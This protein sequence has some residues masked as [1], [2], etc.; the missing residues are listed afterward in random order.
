VTRRY[1]VPVVAA[2][3]LAVAACGDDDGPAMTHAELADA[4]GCTGL[5]EPEGFALSTGEV[6][7]CTLAGDTVHLRVFE[8]N[9]DRDRDLDMIRGVCD[10]LTTGDD[11]TWFAG[12]RWAINAAMPA[13][14][15]EAIE[16]GT[17][18]EP[19]TV[20]C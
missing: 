5:R 19:V 17:G 6:A 2:L 14:A 1:V 7:D 9:G 13:A 10:A 12:N 8:S 16:A 4:I 20:E 18:A 11:V 3:V 15:V